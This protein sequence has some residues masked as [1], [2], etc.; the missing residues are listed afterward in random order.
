M[1]PDFRAIAETSGAIALNP[2]SRQRIYSLANS[3]TPPQWTKT[4]VQSSLEDLSYEP[5]NSF[6][7]RLLG[8]AIN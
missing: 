1:F 3:L 5:G 7:R 6:I 8:L 4:F 2:T